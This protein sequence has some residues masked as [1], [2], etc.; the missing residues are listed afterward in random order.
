MAIDTAAGAVSVGRRSSRSVWGQAR[1]VA[2]LSVT[3]SAGLTRVL[4][5][6]AQQTRM[7]DAVVAVLDAALP[8][9]E[10]REAA[11]LLTSRSIPIAETPAGDR[12]SRGG[13]R[14]QVAAALRF[15]RP[16]EADE[17]TSEPSASGRPGGELDG[18]ADA[19]GQWLWLVR[20][21]AAPAPHA[22]QR[23]L[24]AVETAPSVAVAGCK[25]VE[26]DDD[27]RLRDVGVTT[28]RWGA[29][30]TGLDRGELDQGQHDLRSDVLAVRTAGMLVRRD[31]WTDLGG[32]D[33]AL[34]G[35][36]DDL[37][38]CRRVHL[39]GHRVVVV[40]GAVVA[41]ASTA[42][43]ASYRDDRRDALL[44][45]LAW[46]RWW[47]VPVALVWTLL[48]GPARAVV[49]L[50]LKQPSESLDELITTSEVLTRPARWIGARRRIR[51]ARTVPAGA[52]RTLG[53]SVRLLA[54]QRRDEITSWI[55]PSARWRDAPPEPG[56]SRLR[57]AVPGLLA[58]LPALVAGLVA[59]RHLITGAGAV[60]GVHLRP[61]P[62]GIA[63]V[64]REAGPT[65]RPVGLGA[66]A[67]ADPATSLFAVLAL[68]FGTPDRLVTVLLVAG[69][70]VAAAVAYAVT[71]SLTRS[72][73]TRLITALIWSA[74]PPL[75]A[76]VATG[77]PTAVLV[78]LLLPVFALACWRTLTAGSPAA[79]A[80]AG[81]LMTA[82]IAAA[83][84]TAVPLSVLVLV[85][86]G[87]AAVVFG[88]RRLLPVVLTVLIPAV[89][90]LP[91]WAAVARR[92]GL[93]LAGDA[94]WSAAPSSPWWHLMFLPGSPKQLFSLGGPL[95][96]RL[97]GAYLSQA[98]GQPLPPVVGDLPLI[99]VGA[100]AVAIALAVPVIVLAAAALFRRGGA[101]RVAVFGWLIALIGLA[102]ALVGE[103]ILVAGSRVWSGP[104]LSV[105]LLGVAIAV[106]AVLPQVG[107]R[108]RRTGPWR[109]RLLSPVLVLLAVP[110]LTALAVFA[111][112]DALAVHR[113][114][115]ALLPAVAAAEGDG[116]GATRALVLAVDGERIR[117]SLSRGSVQRWGE[118]SADR[119]LAGFSGAAA[120][121]DDAVV[122]PVISGLLSPAGRDQRSA[123]AG[124]GV[125]SVA[126]L[127]PLDETAERALDG[128]P[129]LVRVNAGAGRAMWRV[130]P[131]PTERAS[132]RTYRVRVIDP[133][134]VVRAVLPTARDGVSVEADVPQGA[135]GRRVVLAEAADPGWQARYDG[136]A[137]VAQTAG[138]NGWAQAFVLPAHA[139]RLQLG[140]VGPSP[141]TASR[142]VDGARWVTALL[143]LLLALPLPRVRSRIA[144]PPAP[145]PTHPVARESTQETEIR[146][147]PRVFDLDHPEEG[148]LP[149]VLPDVMPDVMPDV[150]D[151]TEVADAVDVADADV[152]DADVSGDASTEATTEG[153]PV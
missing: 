88:A 94:P 147:A 23:L 44:L 80:A 124:L 11:E 111:S 12:V 139:G 89:V 22:L 123:L 87:T 6:L 150:A 101:G 47:L 29:V 25:Q 152:A 61:M 130:D 38:F 84:A 65:W 35:A 42:P 105:A 90:L 85:A 72:R 56:P 34:V 55:R 43:R 51:S 112:A 102:A 59:G 7:P 113:S 19:R 93:L 8:A 144:P 16:E 116:P 31:V 110:S 141:W 2:I 64:W 81:A 133:D 52:V 62:D 4:D 68:P 97:G 79:A 32:P 125:G 58:S 138:T 74:A 117:W 36:R 153:S 28:S 26:W 63:G 9:V 99:V 95:A 45:R 24:A 128:A 39:R 41:A 17:A 5:A 98:V 40:P 129:G 145:R 121:R 96:E 75:L 86:A 146:P 60:T 37:E 14:D 10:A 149:D 91:W 30:I 103:R 132:A 67:I 20:S 92:P 82:L 18:A 137:L 104:A 50:V 66:S 70:A 148:E 13:L 120:Q 54:R 135:A 151:L 142:W 83:P 143:A 118:D 33:R 48:A 100:V 108:M 119:R 78:H 57:R 71:A 69:P 107:R 115:T 140:H 136:V 49:R 21:D 76:A 134:G 131:A 122:L 53:A 3:G 109:R 15:D 114:R 127:E 73:P 77:R 27:Q 126:L 1:V 46:T 106:V